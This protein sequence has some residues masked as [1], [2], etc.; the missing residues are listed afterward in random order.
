MHSHN[1][2]MAPITTES[3]TRFRKEGV[4]HHFLSLYHAKCKEAEQLAANDALSE[5]KGTIDAHISEANKELVNH[6]EKLLLEVYTDAKN[7]TSSVFSRPARY[8]P[9]EAGNSYNF[10]SDTGTIPSDISI[11]YVNPSSHLD[12]LKNIEQSYRKQFNAKIESARSIALTSIKYM[13]SLK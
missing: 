9:S 7:L 1:K 11:Q 6:I 10:D 5:D 8:I 13:F 4:E 2:K 12:L 3:G